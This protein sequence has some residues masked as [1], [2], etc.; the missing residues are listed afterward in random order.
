M[1]P[2]LGHLRR[3]WGEGGRDRRDVAGETKQ[4][5]PSA[6]GGRDRTEGRRRSGASDVRRGRVFA[7]TARGAPLR[8]T[9]GVEKGANRGVDKGGNSLRIRG[10]GSS[11]G[12]VERW[13]A[14]VRQ[15]SWFRNGGTCVC[16]R[17]RCLAPGGA[18]R[19]PC[20]VLGAAAIR[21]TR[22][23][24]RQWAVVPQNAGGAALA[25]DKGPAASDGVRKH[26][27][28]GPRCVVPVL[29]ADADSPQAGGRSRRSASS[30]RPGLE[31]SS[32]E[33]GPGS[34]LIGRRA[35]SGSAA[36]RVRGWEN[37]GTGARARNTATGLW[38]NW[39]GRL[40]NRRGSAAARSQAVQEMGGRDEGRDERLGEDWRAVE[41]G[42]KY[43][44]GWPGGGGDVLLG[45]LGC[46]FGSGRAWDRPCHVWS[47]S[48]RDVV[49]LSGF[50]R[51]SAGDVGRARGP[52]CQR[53]G[54]ATQE[55]SFL[56]RPAHC[57][58]PPV[59]FGAQG[60]IGRDALR[61]ALF[62]VGP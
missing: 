11:S 61:V 3:G 1:F 19:A 28:A 49:H 54:P 10:R 5:G 16:A 33:R 40:G 52:I 6:V 50:E 24:R 45:S 55:S 62:D 47:C 30:P 14:A 2:P 43:F 26:G 44:T 4:R 15:G 48:R 42:V 37:A 31:L 57:R 35:G 23:R 41:A 22:E 8:D 21:P 51:T 20:R 29:E 32:V 39:V 7:G 46:E 27:L 18:C 36:A 60:T 38:E 17:M 12:K 34:P 58:N 53:A 9:A 25:G 59:L 56:A 13:S